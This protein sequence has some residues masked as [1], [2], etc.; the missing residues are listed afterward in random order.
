MQSPCCS[1]PVPFAGCVVWRNCSTS[2]RCASGTWDSPQR[3][4][5]WTVLGLSFKWKQLYVLDK[6]GIGCHGINNLWRVSCGKWYLII[7]L[8]YLQSQLHLDNDSGLKGWKVQ[9]TSCLYCWTHRLHIMCERYPHVKHLVRKYMLLVRQRYYQKKKKKANQK[10]NK[11]KQTKVC[12]SE[13]SWMV[14][15]YEFKMW[16]IF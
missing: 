2:C 16:K 11:Q 6:Y 15:K 13:F 5:L 7:A 12:A 9:R 14:K 1:G 4:D 8:S 10:T 3:T